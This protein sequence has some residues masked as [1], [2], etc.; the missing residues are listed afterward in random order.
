MVCEPPGVHLWLSAF[1]PLPLRFTACTCE[2]S[3][4][5][6]PA[7]TLGL[8]LGL[9]NRPC[10]SVQHGHESSNGARRCGV[11]KLLWRD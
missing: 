8:T 2:Q 9:A 3:F 6:T 4:A 7:L 11:I 10:Q 5:L 1:L